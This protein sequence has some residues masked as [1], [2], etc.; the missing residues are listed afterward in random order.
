MIYK[1]FEL[2]TNIGT[3]YLDGTL[4]KNSDLDMLN[5]YLILILFYYI[6]EIRSNSE[7]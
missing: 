5:F 6:L 7:M 4:P 3:L 1:F 2:H